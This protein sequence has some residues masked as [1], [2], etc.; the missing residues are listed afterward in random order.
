MRLRRTVF[1]AASFQAMKGQVEQANAVK[2]LLPS[3]YSN[4]PLNCFIKKKEVPWFHDSA[5][6][7]LVALA[8]DN[9]VLKDV[10]VS[11]T[12]G[13]DRER[14]MEAQVWVR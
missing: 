5:P 9:L 8:A 2:W 4:D 3:K 10:S 14:T 1:V 12:L 11:P 7:L 13:E 6:P